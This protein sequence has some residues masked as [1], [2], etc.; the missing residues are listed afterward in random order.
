MKPRSLVLPVL[1]L[2]A[3][4]GCTLLDRES[5]SLM[6]RKPAHIYQDPKQAPQEPVDTDVAKGAEDDGEFEES[7]DLDSF[8]RH[9]LDALIEGIG[10]KL[11]PFQLFA[12]CHLHESSHWLESVV[13][14]ALAP[15]EYPLAVTSQFSYM[16][17]ETT[18]QVLMLP[19][20]FLFPPP[21]LPPNYE[22]RRPE[23][24]R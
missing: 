24:R 23:R 4:S 2:V 20:E 22:Y 13:A 9:D 6:F 11:E 18:I 5:Y 8:V 16:A 1:L 14:I 19:L 21:D 7:D 3:G 10:P 15:V 17:I 12:W